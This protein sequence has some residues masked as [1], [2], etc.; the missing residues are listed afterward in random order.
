MTH[1]E[2]EEII[3]YLSRPRNYDKG[4]ALYDRYGH[5]RMYKR[6]F[7]FEETECTR[8]M[9]IEE[10]RKLAGL[11]EAELKRLPRMTADTVAAMAGKSVTHVFFDEPIKNQPAP[12]PAAIQTGIRIR[13]RFSFLQ[14]PNCPDIL[15][16]IVADMLTAHQ[17][18]KTAFENLQKLADDQT[19]AAFTEAAKVVESY[20]VNKEAWDELEHY[21]NTGTILGKAKRFREMAE[22]EDLA[23]LSDMELL[24]KLNSAKA[25]QSKRKAELKKA[26]EAGTD[27][28]IAA[29][30]L[31]RW[32]ATRARIEAEIDTRKKK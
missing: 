24:R 6:R 8:S 11:T 32:T 7:M 22:G 31:D 17:E 5:N 29:E 14:R 13:E 30:A 12:A 26:Q 28:Q 27:T 23:A 4:V 10:L 25:N 19:A 16:I 3:R 20:L 9:L 18:Y 1:A 15:K 2:R 21:Q